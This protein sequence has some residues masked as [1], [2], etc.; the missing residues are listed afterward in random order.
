MGRNNPNWYQMLG[1]WLRRNMGVISGVATVV[2]VII[3]IVR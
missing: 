3:G 1:R 2:G